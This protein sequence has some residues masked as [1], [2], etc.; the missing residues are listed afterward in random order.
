M[1]GHWAHTLAHLSQFL[2]AHQWQGA[3]LGL[4]N[5]PTPPPANSS[6]NGTP[7]GVCL[8][9]GSEPIPPKLVD[10]VCSG[11]YVDMK[12]LLRDNIALLRQLEGLNIATTLPAL[13]GALKPRLREVTSLASWLYCFLAYA[14]MRCPD[15]ESRDRLAYA[16]IMIREAQR[17]G[18]QGW[19]EYNKVFCQQAALDPVIK[20]NALH[21]A[22]Q[23]STLQ[24]GLPTSSSG[25]QGH[26][27]HFCTLCRGVDHLAT[28]CI[29]I[30]GPACGNSPQSGMCAQY[31]SS[32]TQ[33]WS[34]RAGRI[35][36]S[37]DRPVP[38]PA[39]AA[40]RNRL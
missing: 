20:C 9:P 15:Q 25:S 39:L 29:S 33:Q 31:V 27:G 1:A 37:P 32:I 36:G 21:P 22:I 5:S 34:V 13:P 23:A 11:V 2:V 18:G 30:F 10:K 24:F 17:H 40:D 26:P 14:A 6:V 8:S 28:A 3:H 35:G 38:H 7:L 19:L 4:I 12:E 16:R